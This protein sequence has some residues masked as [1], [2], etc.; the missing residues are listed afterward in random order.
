MKK[1]ADLK[2]KDAPEYKVG[3]LVMLDGRNIQIRRLKD[4]LDHKKHSTFA[5]E[6]VVSPTAI[7]LS[8]PE[9]WKIDNTFYVSLL[10]PYN[11]GPRSLRDLL[12]IINE[13]NDI[14]CNEEWEIEEILS[15]RKVTGKV[16]YQVRWKGH[17]HKKDHTEE[18]YEYFIVGSLEAL[19]EFCNG[20]QGMGTE[21]RELVA[22]GDGDLGAGMGVD[23]A[24]MRWRGGALRQMRLFMVRTG[25]R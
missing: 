19:Q 23:G 8:L 13:S 4:K 18:P 9:K 25:A 14:E 1:Y 11:N 22:G 12:N 2:R 24:A 5:I 17:P 6:K 20:G 7:R 15:R 21:S 16:L 10:D 3:D